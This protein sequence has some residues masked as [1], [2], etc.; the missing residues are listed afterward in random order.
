MK[1]SAPSKD[2]TSSHS[3]EKITV[4]DVHVVTPKQGDVWYKC[5]FVVTLSNHK[6]IRVK[7]DKMFY[8][9]DDFVLMMNKTRSAIH[10]KSESMAI[11]LKAGNG[12]LYMKVV[13]DK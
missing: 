4:C 5:E 1:S 11:D 8:E 3:I 9:K 12:P 7:T 2:P 13:Y 6:R 10:G